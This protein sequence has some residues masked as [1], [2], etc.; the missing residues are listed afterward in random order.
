V[1][2]SNLQHSAYLPTSICADGEFEGHFFNIDNEQDGESRKEVTH[3][4][5]YHAHALKS[6][7]AK[8]AARKSGELAVR[9]EKSPEEY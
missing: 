1:D 6:S 3:D 2:I 5:P 4:A 9:T 7:T 8:C